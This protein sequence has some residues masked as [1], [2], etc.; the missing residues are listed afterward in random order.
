MNKKLIQVEVGEKPKFTKMNK[1]KLTAL[2]QCATT[3][4][5]N[6][7][8][9]FDTERF[10]ELVVGECVAAVLYAEVNMSSYMASLIE[11]RFGYEGNHFSD[12]WFVEN[13]QKD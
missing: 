9:V 3:T 1:E 5:T 7:N 2:K 10:A 11:T 8:E 13:W 4:D 6:G 12:K